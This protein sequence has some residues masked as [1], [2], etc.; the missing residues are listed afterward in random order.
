MWAVVGGM[1]MAQWLFEGLSLALGLRAVGE[2]NIVGLA[3]FELIIGSLASVPLKTPRSTVNLETGLALALWTVTFLFVLRPSVANFDVAAIDVA[4]NETIASLRYALLGGEIPVAQG[5]GN[6]TFTGL[7]PLVGLWAS[8]EPLGF[9]AVANTDIVGTM[10]HL[11]TAAIIASIGGGLH[12]D[13]V[14]TVVAVGILVIVAG[15]L[16]AIW[17]SPVT[18]TPKSG[19]LASMSLL[20][21]CLLIPYALVLNGIPRSHDW[22]LLVAF[23]LASYLKRH[24]RSRC[25][26][27][28]P[29]ATGAAGLG[30]LRASALLLAIH[31]SS[32]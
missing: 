27:F 31:S 29:S 4:L 21:G 30:A 25:H 12:E 17:S 18:S 5:T 28:F 6:V 32:S 2:V 11:G 19:G 24:L 13:G 9:A 26:A 7:P 8:L 23:A 14:T 10:T 1:V 20:A 3:S 15:T 22:G 16:A